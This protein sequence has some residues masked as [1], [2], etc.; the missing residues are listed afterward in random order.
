MDNKKSSKN[1]IKRIFSYFY[2]YKI[3]V[4]LVIIFTIFESLITVISPKIAGNSITIL[5]ETDFLG[6]PNINMN[7]FFNLLAILVVMYSI[8][9]FCS[10][11]GRY[12]FTNISTN[13]VYDF[14]NEISQK[15]HKLSFKY[16]DSKTRGE[17]LSYIVNDAEVLSSS[18]IDNIKDLISSSIVSIGTIY[19]MFSI[20]WKMTLVCFCF[21]P[22]IILLISIVMKHS[23]K[24]F[25]GYRD[26][27]SKINGH[28]EE[29]FSGYETIKALG[30][31]KSFLNKFDDINEALYTDLFNSSFISRLTP[32]IIEFIS[33]I[34]YV[35]C[36][37]LGGYLSVVKGM[38]IGNIVSFMTYSTQFINPFLTLSGI[39]SNFQNCFAAA[40]R[41][42]EF[43]DAPEEYTHNNIIKEYLTDSYN[44]EI[45][46]KNVNFSY[47]ENNK[48]ISD[49]S[50]KIKP[51][52]TI[53]IVGETGSGKTTLTKLLMRFYDVNS[54]EI[55]INGKNINNFD[56]DSYRKKF[57]I[58]TQDSWLYNSS[59]LEN[60]RY[61]NL[62]AS[63]EKVKEI[64]SFVGIENFIE[65]LPNGYNT[66]I[67]EMG[68]NLSGTKTINMYCSSSSFKP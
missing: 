33:K 5:S 52:Q 4:I 19:M 63:D 28:I 67:E 29:C 27:L 14:R 7:N 53:A 13:I 42:F 31:E 32:S 18:F 62:E 22:I 9:S 48:A 44:S 49:F 59:I 36:C 54:G 43:L 2:K 64:A 37:V 8:E 20:S 16:L 58:V 6:N 25:I 50:F 30:I 21:I 24:Y 38:E 11:L 15:I 56:I 68:S 40:T 51:G 3:S 65:S 66:I 60:I 57:S 41:I 23:Q 1:I 12:I 45:E 55:L 39:S 35:V 10:C 34:I 47:D 26:K 46:F 61:G 17:I